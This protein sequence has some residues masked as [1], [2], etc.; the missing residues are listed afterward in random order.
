[1]CELCSYLLKEPDRSFPPDSQMRAW[2]AMNRRK[3][4]TVFLSES[5]KGGRYTLLDLYLIFDG[6]RPCEQPALPGVEP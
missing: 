6:T 3:F 2:N 1:M 4:P 5:S